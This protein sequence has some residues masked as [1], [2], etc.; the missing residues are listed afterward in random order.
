MCTGVETGGHGVD[1]EQPAGDLLCFLIG[2]PVRN[3]CCSVSISVVH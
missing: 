3:L 1:L 2:L